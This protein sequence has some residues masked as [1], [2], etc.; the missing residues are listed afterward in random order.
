MLIEIEN[1][2]KKWS[3]ALENTLPSLGMGCT[4]VQVLKIQHLAT[5]IKASALFYRDELAYDAFTTNFRE[6]INLAQSIIETTMKTGGDL[7]FS[8]DLGIILPLYF[9]ACK[10][11]DPVLRRKAISLLNRSGIEGLWDGGAMAA[12]ATWAMKYEGGF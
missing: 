11:R 10:C 1:L 9:T 12:V 4:A 8:F 5:T 7:T 6:I 3:L 2:L